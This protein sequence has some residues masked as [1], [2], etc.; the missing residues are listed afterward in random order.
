MPEPG[1]L[2]TAL[3]LA[4]TALFLMAGPPRFRWR[5]QARIAALAL[6]GAAFLAAAVYA[7]LW[8]LGIVG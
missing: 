3:A 2:I 1:Q 6:Y 8:A 5:R 7:L 4:A